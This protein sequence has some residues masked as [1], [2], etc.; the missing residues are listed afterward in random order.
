MES[1]FPRGGELGVGGKAGGT[2][3]HN[4]CFQF[5][6]KKIPECLYKSGLFLD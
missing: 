3:C 2:T 5:G 1:Q 4:T 6:R